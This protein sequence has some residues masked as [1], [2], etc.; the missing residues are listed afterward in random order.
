MFKFSNYEDMHVEAQSKADALIDH[1][2]KDYKFQY[3]TL[4]DNLFVLADVSSFQSIINMVKLYTADNQK[5][6]L[7][8]LS[9]NHNHENAAL[10]LK[11]Q[12]NNLGMFASTI[13]IPYIAWSFPEDY[14]NPHG[15]EFQHVFLFFVTNYKEFKVAEECV[16]YYANKFDKIGEFV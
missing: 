3:S 12:I 16:A 5:L 11:D 10:D 7:V 14:D 9:Y 13:D 4:I 2:K 6:Q 1:L 8:V 15:P